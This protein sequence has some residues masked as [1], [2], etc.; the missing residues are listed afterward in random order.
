VAERLRHHQR[1]PGRPTRQD[2]FVIL[3]RR[4]G[5]TDDAV[6]VAGGARRDRGTGLVDGHELTVSASIG[7][8]ERQVADT[9]PGELMRA[10]DSTLHWAKA[11][12]VRAGRSSTPTATGS[13]PT[14]LRGDPG[15]L[16]R[17][18]SIWTTSR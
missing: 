7:I 1:A 18:S 17:G 10:A 15:R 14:P 6:K 3:V 4:H 9:S 2:E 5:C 11:P 16:N 8:V 13:W 12:V